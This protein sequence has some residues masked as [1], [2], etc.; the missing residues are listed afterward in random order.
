MRR[1]R[2]VRILGPTDAPLALGTVRLD[3]DPSP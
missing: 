3:Q 2:I 1:L